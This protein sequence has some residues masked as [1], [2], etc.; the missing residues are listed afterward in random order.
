[1]PRPLVKSGMRGLGQS[2]F[3]ES[4]REL[5]RR[6]GLLDDARILTYTPV[7]SGGATRKTYTPAADTVLARVDPVGAGTSGTSGGAV[8]E[9]STHMITF[10]AG[11]DINT[12][13]RIRL[14]GI[15]WIITAEVER[16]DE[17]V[18]RVEVQQV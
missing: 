18:K 16:T 6:M 8:N 9:A 14:H 7:V 1:M 5:G 3:P 17:L 10:T 15:D 2:I 13:D 11:Q 12:E 4:A